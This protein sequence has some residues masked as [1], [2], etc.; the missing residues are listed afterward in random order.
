M[1]KNINRRR[2]VKTSIA[3]TAGLSL[4]PQSGF[5]MGRNP[6][7]PKNLPV[8][9]LGKTGLKVP[10]I[11]F[12]AGSRWMS[13][14]DDEK[15]LSILEYALDNGVY[16]WDTA[17]NYG[18]DR[19]S[20]EERIGKIL[21]DKRDKV[22]LVTKT[23]HREADEAKASIEQSLKR[24]RTDYIDILHVHA[25][26]STEDAESLGEKGK[27]L[28]VLH[29]YRDQG[30]IKHIGFTGHSSAEGMKRAAELYDFEVM[31]I[32][33]NHAVKGGAQDFEKH[34]VPVAHKKGMGVVAMKVIR[35]RESV[36][37]IEP[38]SL[39]RYALSSEH[40]SIANI[41]T[42]SKEVLDANLEIIR[43]FKA[44]SP[45]E[46]EQLEARLTPFFQ[47]ENVAWMKPGYFDGYSGEMY[48]ANHK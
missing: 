39:L 32:A 44:L 19:I 36:E 24:L 8:R 13:I 43:N 10:L 38:S 47:H 25:I 7:D 6:F 1:D 42:D 12:G 5:S 27:V 29:D 28:E 17:A 4:L 33:M 30:I 34:A 15:A 2:F 14:Q 48:L 35:P 18:N 11:G 20:S 23:H 22:L 16:Y 41:G 9:K 45:S 37:G 3:A 26:K 21:K 46:T 31:M 40:F